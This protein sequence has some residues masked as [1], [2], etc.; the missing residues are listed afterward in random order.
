[1]LPRATADA[2]AAL[3][4]SETSSMEPTMGDNRN[5]NGIND[6]ETDADQSLP[7]YLVQWM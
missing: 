6:L 1:M 3:I 5:R 2:P 4:A 7:K